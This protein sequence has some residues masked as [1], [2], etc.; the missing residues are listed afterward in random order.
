[1]FN[2]K[3]GNLTFFLAKI[4]F[5]ICPNPYEFLQIFSNLPNFLLVLKKRLKVTKFGYVFAN[6]LC[7]RLKKVLVGTVTP[8]T[9][10]P[11]LPP[12]V[13][14]E[15][16]TLGTKQHSEFNYTRENIGRARLF[17]IRNIYTVRSRFLN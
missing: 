13:S 9:Q 12:S 6:R 10:G 16:L 8:L 17:S 1:M 3:T 11:Y 5:S 4:E 14:S 2:K 7:T 15:M